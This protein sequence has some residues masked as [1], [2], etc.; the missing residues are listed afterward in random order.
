MIH[1][2]QCIK[3]KA[4]LKL[5]VL[6]SVSSNAVLSYT[7]PPGSA[8][9]YHGNSTAAVTLDAHSFFFDDKRAYVFSGE[10]HTWRIPS[11]KPLWRDVFEK[12]KASL[13]VILAC[14]HIQQPSC[15]DRL[16]AL[17]Q[18]QSIITGVSLRES[19]AS[20]TL[21][22]TGRKLTCIRLQ[23][24]SVYLLYHDLV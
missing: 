17:T 20:W 3:M 14:S 12:M 24:K 11:G 6:L 7:V 21:S 15:F 13:I 22:I 2:Y 23:R 16:Q 8:G 9:F 19:R 10:V 1:M 4:L 5:F 18:F